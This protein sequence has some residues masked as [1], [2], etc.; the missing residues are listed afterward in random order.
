MRLFCVHVY[1]F[2][3]TKFRVWI[4]WDEFGNESNLAEMRCLR[5]TIRSTA[6]VLLFII[7]AFELKKNNVGL[8]FSFTYCIDFALTFPSIAIGSNHLPLE[9]LVIDPWHKQSFQTATRWTKQNEPRVNFLRMGNSVAC[10]RTH[11]QSQRTVKAQSTVKKCQ[12]ALSKCQK[13]P[14][15]K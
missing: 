7:L 10:I 3:W 8:V 6:F 13:I 12:M 2:D 9:R 4:S 11:L 5:L 1:A 15:H 14:I